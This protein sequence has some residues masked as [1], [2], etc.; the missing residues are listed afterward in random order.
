MAAQD[1]DQLDPVQSS[2]RP[3]ERI[4]L[5]PVA[6]PVRAIRRA[7]DRDPPVVM[8]GNVPRRGAKIRGEHSPP[9]PLVRIE[10]RLTHRTDQQLIQAN[11]PRTAR[12]P[13]VSAR[14]C[15]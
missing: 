8:A 7:E 4:G 3:E 12:D 9:R 11:T 1:F 13:A 5:Q 14:P 6:K 2:S 10:E 15:R